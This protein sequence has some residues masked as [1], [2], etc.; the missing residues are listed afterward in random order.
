MD[1]A[2]E[3]EKK[4]ERGLCR[5]RRSQIGSVGALCA[6]KGITRRLRDVHVHVDAEATRGHPGAIR[7]ASP[8]TCSTTPA[9][10]NA[11]QRRRRPDR[12]FDDQRFLQ[13]PQYEAG[14]GPK[15]TS[16]SRV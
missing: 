14:T 15:S 10:Q 2:R 1:H 8:E 9:A 12:F 7:V 3:G 11:E 6:A 5:D 16:G 13:M 4:S